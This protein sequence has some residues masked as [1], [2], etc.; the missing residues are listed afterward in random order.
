M[1]DNLSEFERELS[2]FGDCVQILVG[3]EVGGKLSP[4]DTYQQIK[5]R[6]KELK[7]LRK[8]EKQNLDDLL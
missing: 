3:L 2:R 7:R 8:V 1:Y 6:M 4:E 5:A